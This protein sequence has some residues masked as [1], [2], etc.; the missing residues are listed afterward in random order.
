MI[1]T[2]NCKKGEGKFKKQ[3]E[4]CNKDYMKNLK[5]SNTYGSQAICLTIDYQGHS[6]DS[7]NR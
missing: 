3:L 7:I 6:K 2:E 4:Q 1:L 5:I